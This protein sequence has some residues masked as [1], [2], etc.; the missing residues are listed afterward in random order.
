MAVMVKFLS[1]K[2]TSNLSPGQFVLILA[3]PMAIFLSFCLLVADPQ[4]SHSNLQKS[5]KIRNWSR[6][7]AKEF[8]HEQIPIAESVANTSCGKQ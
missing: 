3:R 6:V 1:H 2:A 8:E 4:Q 5:K 7:N